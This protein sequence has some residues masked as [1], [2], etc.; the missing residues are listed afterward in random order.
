MNQAEFKELRMTVADMLCGDDLVD[1]TPR[2]LLYGV[3]VEFEHVHTYFDGVD[4]LMCGWD[5]D[6]DGA[7]ELS[8]SSNEQ[9]ILEYLV[10]PQYCDLEFCQLLLKAGECIPFREWYVDKQKLRT[11]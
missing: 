5:K 3:G 4:I 11:L 6:D 8:P 1:K 10:H 2:T 9:Y 7:C